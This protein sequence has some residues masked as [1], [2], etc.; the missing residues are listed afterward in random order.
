MYAQARIGLKGGTRIGRTFDQLAER[1]RRQRGQGL[2][3]FEQ[4][5][6]IRRRRPG[7]RRRRRGAGAGREQQREGTREGGD[8]CVLAH[9]LAAGVMLSHG[10]PP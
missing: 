9:R 5:A 1:L 7:G 8:E 4:D 3:G 2:D 10:R 6:G